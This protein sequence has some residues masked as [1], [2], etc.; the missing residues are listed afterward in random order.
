MNIEQPI[1]VK[2]IIVTLSYVYNQGLT[3]TTKDI[4]LYLDE[5]EYYD[6][7]DSDIFIY[8]GQGAYQ[9][10]FETFVKPDT[11]DDELNIIKQRIIEQFKEYIQQKINYLNN[12]L[13]ILNDL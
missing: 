12:G 1:L 5:F 9:Y 7:E 13:E 2:Q 3:F 4:E 10:V 6:P 11:S 8:S